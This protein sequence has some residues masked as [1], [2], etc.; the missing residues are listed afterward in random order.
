V[1]GYE[2]EDLAARYVAENVVGESSAADCTHIA[3]ATIAHADVLVSWN[4]KH[5]VKRSEGYK[6]VNK[7]LE[8]PEIEIQ[9]P[10][11]FMETYYDET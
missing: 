2:T 5:M 6:S 4:L 9:T 10:E 3:L 1:N 7:A 8:Y 11:K